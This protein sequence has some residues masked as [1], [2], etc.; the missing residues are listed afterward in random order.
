ME[1]GRF[2]AT[3]CVDPDALRYEIAR[4]LD[5]GRR[6]IVASAHHGPMKKRPIGVIPGVDG[7][8]IR[9]AAAREPG[10]DSF[11]VSLSSGL[12]N[13]KWKVHFL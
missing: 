11:K 1:R 8:W 5:V 6:D 13:I 7:S 3:F 10:I 2:L 12:S 4:K 9:R